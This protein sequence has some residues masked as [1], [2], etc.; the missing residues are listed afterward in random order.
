MKELSSFDFNFRGPGSV[1]PKIC[2]ENNAMPTSIDSTGFK[3]QQNNDAQEYA[4]D[5]KNKIPP[6]FLAITLYHGDL[7]VPG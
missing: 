3:C 6:G 4:V 7:Q 1:W 5:G 2:S